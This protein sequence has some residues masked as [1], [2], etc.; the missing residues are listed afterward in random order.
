MKIKRLLSVSIFIGAVFF[1]VNIGRAA[2]ETLRITCW[3]GYADAATVKEF[4]DL[5]KKK[6]GIDVEV[7]ASYPTNQD[8]FYKAAKDGTTDLIS[9][10]ADLAKTP[11]FYCFHE[12]KLLLAEPDLKNIPN[13]KNIIPFF[14]ADQSL[15]HQKKRYGLSPQVCRRCL[16]MGILPR[17]RQAGLCFSSSA[18][19]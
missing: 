13:A 18:I 9:P 17:Y 7:K 10:P 4:K 2:Q 11:R 3:E 12:G 15:T 1:C 14:A 19:I 16:E 5:V 6:Y 8:E